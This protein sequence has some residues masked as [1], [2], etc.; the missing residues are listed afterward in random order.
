MTPPAPVSREFTAHAQGLAELDDWIEAAT[1]GWPCGEALLKARVCVAE[2]AANLM[3]HGCDASSPA[4][5]G[6]RLEPLGK[7]IRLELSDDGRPFDPTQWRP[8]AARETLQTAAIG[9]R[10]LRTVHGLAREMR[11][12]RR[13]DRNHLSL[14]VAGG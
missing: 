1:A 6:V 4:R 13:D 11:Y 3:E 2:L 7:D 14:L 10:G 12:E 9:G 8:A 5:L